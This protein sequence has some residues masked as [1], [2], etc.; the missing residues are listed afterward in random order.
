MVHVHC[1]LDNQGYR[2]THTLSKYNTY[3]AKNGYANGPQCYVTCTFSVLFSA[4]V[5]FEVLTFIL[6]N[7]NCLRH[8]RCHQNTN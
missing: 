6:Y 2:H 8:C 1:M 3:T 5:A 4:V 7:A